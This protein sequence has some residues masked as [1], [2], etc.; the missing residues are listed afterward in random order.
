MKGKLAPRTLAAGLIFGAILLV[1]QNL[2]YRQDPNWR[3]S[4][5]AA[6]RKNPLVDRRDVTS[7]GQ[8]LF[9]RHCLECHGPGGSGRGRAA[10]LQAPEVQ[11]QSDGALFWKISSGNARRGMPS[12]SG[13]PELQRWQLVMF[14][15]T[16]KQRH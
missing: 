13:L 16:L 12:F 6:A 15:R 5:K 9:E 14:L 2:A 11:Q 1:G 4:A 3:A 7:G 8:R 10:N